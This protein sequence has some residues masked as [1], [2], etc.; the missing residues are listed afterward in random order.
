M[1]NI[2]YSN[3]TVYTDALEIKKPLDVKL[4]KSLSNLNEIIWSEED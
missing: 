2:L 4:F 1:N 3:M